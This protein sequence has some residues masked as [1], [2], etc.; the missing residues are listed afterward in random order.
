MK[1]I[2]I[3][4]HAKS[5]WG[6]LTQPDF[7]RPLND[8]GFKDAPEMAKR[9][10]KKEAKID[11]FV[12]S[13]ANRAK[14]TCEFF[15]ET[16]GKSKKDILFIDELYHAPAATF[17]AVIS[18]LEDEFKSVA[19]FS[20]NPGITEFVNSLARGVQIDNMPTCGIFAVEAPIKSW[21]EFEK[22]ER[23]FLFVDYP[24]A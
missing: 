2:Y 21:A 24:K 16:F 6:N 1:T 19:I 9:L 12:S 4:R 3:V 23:K 11:L 10:K 8:R 14:T 13:P 17:Y 15:C 22:A 5:S 18:E 7:D 20:H